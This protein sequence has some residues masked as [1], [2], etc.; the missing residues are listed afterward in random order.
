MIVS[1][2]SIRNIHNPYF[3]YDDLILFGVKSIIGLLA[4][5]KESI[6]ANL[7]DKIL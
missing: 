1:I 2:M 5:V 4:K 7:V 6:D 3:H